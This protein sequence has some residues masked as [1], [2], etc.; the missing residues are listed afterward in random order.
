MN[1]LFL[2]KESPE[3]L[4]FEGV[5]LNALSETEFHGHSDK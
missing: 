1:S 2:S 5:S 3:S 4:L